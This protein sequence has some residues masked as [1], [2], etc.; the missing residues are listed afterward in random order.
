MPD[1]PQP[2]GAGAARLVNPGAG[3]RRTVTSRVSCSRYDRPT[4]M[5]DRTF[6]M[7]RVVS[8]RQEDTQVPTVIKPWSSLQNFNTFQPHGHSDTCMQADGAGPARHSL[9]GNKTRAVDSTT[10]TWISG[11][12]DA[13][14]CL[15][16]G[17][18]TAWG[19]WALADV[20]PS[21]SL[22]TRAFI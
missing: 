8:W 15:S 18:G 7:R 17:A 12:G 14:S 1:K 22:T 20:T 13:S 4:L 11:T 9:P 16:T 3:M 21:T 10:S 2:S 5:P 19:S 6:R